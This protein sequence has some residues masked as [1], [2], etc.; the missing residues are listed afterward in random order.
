[1]GRVD[2]RNVME[3]GDLDFD[4]KRTGDRLGIDVNR[5]SGASVAD[6]RFYFEESDLDDRVRFRGW[7]WV[8]SCRFHNDP[9]WGFAG[10]FRFQPLHQA[11]GEALFGDFDI[12]F[13]R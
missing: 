4:C 11:P 6:A 10:G 7:V 5:G 12:D 2:T 8:Q 1:V 13:C 9:E 3:S